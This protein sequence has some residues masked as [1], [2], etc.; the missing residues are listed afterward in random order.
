VN[1]VDRDSGA[2]DAHLPDAG[3]DELLAR[4]D[5]YCDTAPRATARVEEHGSLTLFVAQQGWPFYARPALARDTEPSPAQI[6]AVLARQLQLG[7]PRELE[8]IHETA[9]SLAGT[10]RIAGMTVHE[11]PL[12]VLGSLIEPRRA[13]GEV[14][15]MDADDPELGI[16]NAALEVAFATPGTSVGKAGV[17]GRDNAIGASAAASQLAFTMDA[18]RNGRTV[19]VGAFV[20]SAGAVGGGS[21]NP[22][23]AVSEIRGVG[24]LPA[25]RRRGL[26]GAVVHRLACQ[27]LQM[28]ANTVFCG[29]ESSVVARIYEQVGFS[30]IGTIC[31]AETG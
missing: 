3:S 23:G 20:S 7:V 8:W 28:G 27:A 1:V 11:Y 9:P 29:A 16:V 17:A 26:A 14:R 6:H 25:F 12:L 22:R 18:L 2:P 31:L 19:R 5:D 10:A 13:D 15:L 24:T 4:I 30:R 21:H